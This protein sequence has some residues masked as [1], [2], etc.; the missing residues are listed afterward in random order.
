MFGVMSVNAQAQ[1]T[2]VA[3][4]KYREFTAKIY[5]TNGESKTVSLLVNTELEVVNHGEPEIPAH[6]HRDYNVTG[7]VVEGDKRCDFGLLLTQGF[8]TL[9]TTSQILAGNADRSGVIRL[10]SGLML[11]VSSVKALMG[12]K[13]MEMNLHAKGLTKAIGTGPVKFEGL[14]IVPEPKIEDWDRY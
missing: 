14:K 10:C 4:Q 6:G 13:E 11:S 8:E 9:A 3:G 1:V 7:T 12:E 5:V 2:S